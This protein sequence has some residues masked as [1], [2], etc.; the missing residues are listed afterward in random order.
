MVFVNMPFD[1]PNVRCEN[2]KAL[3]KTRIG[4]LRSVSNIPRVFA[5]QS[6]VCEVAHK[7]GRD[8]KDFLLELIGPDRKLNPK[9]L[10]FPEDYWHYGDPYEEYPL[11]TAR[12]KNVIRVAAEKAGWGKKL[13]KGEGLGIA[14][15]CA[16][17]SYVATIVH[18]AMDSDGTVRV[19]EVHTVVDCGLYV[20][21]DRIRSQTE[22]AAVMGMS[23]TLYSGITCAEGK[24]KLL[25]G[26]VTQ[27]HGDCKLLEAVTV[28]A[29]EG[30]QRI[31]CNAMLPFFGLTMKLGPVANWGLNLAE[32][33]IPVDTEK[34]E[35]SEP[36]IFAI[37]DINTY[38]GKLKL[39]LSG[40]H[41]AALMAQAAHRYVYP[42]KKV[43]FQ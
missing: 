5:T 11:D 7:L 21:A 19:P 28:K 35:T 40:F 22:G 1:I 27:L 37:G 9:A 23:N 16:W 24:V 10:G 14:A 43:L 17:Q 15:H 2:G 36:G 38:P 25:I 20:N 29:K 12:F 33:L 34:F 30:E 41:E 3:A 32:N 13:P 8:P 39:I 4:W 42:D 18:V 26:Q 31:A 6:A